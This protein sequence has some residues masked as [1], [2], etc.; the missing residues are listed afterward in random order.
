[1]SKTPRINYKEIETHQ[2][3]SVMVEKIEPDHCCLCASECKERKATHTVKIVHYFSFLGHVG[4]GDYCERHANEVAEE[5]KRQIVI[6]KYKS[7]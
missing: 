1:M 3:P 4:R 7:K 2:N 5:Y 6:R